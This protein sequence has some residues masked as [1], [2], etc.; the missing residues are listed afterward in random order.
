M[1]FAIF[2]TLLLVAGIVLVLGKVFSARKRQSRLVQ[3]G[4]VSTWQDIE[5]HPDNFS[6]IVQTDFGHGK[7]VWALSTE[8]DEINLKIRAFKTGI[9][10]VPRPKRSDL[11]KFCQSHGIAFNLK[12]VK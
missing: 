4:Q 9:L 3:R 5:R 12:M 7:E 1:K 10:I 8:T 6:K 2:I 11:E